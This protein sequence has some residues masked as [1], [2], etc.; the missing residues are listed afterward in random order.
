MADIQL[1]HRG[2]G[3]SQSR[4][5]KVPDAGD[6]PAA[7]VAPDP[8]VRVPRG[9]FG[10]DI[11]NS[12][13]KVASGLEALQTA[14]D[15]QQKQFDATETG[16]AQLAI[17][18]D[19]TEKLQQRQ[20]TEDTAHPDFLANTDKSVKASTEAAVAALNK[21]GVS[22]SAQDDFRLRVG[23]FANGLSRSAGQISLAAGEAKA[24]AT[25]D[26]ETN[27]LSAQAQRDPDMLATVL[28]NG[29]SKLDPFRSSMTPQQETAAQVKR[30]ENI[31]L[32]SIQGMAN[33]GRFNEANV[34]LASGTYDAQLDRVARTKAQAMID[35]ARAER[36]RISEKNERLAEKRLKAEG[37]Q[38]LKDFT[39]T[40]A[41]GSLPT[42]QDV[43]RLRRNPGV[44]P[45]EYK[46]ITD[47]LQ[48]K[49]DH[50]N[51][52]FMLRITPRLDSEDVVAEIGHAAREHIIT[53]KTA[54]SLMEKNR[55]QRK[56][57][58]PASPFQS[59]KKFLSVALDPG[60]IG[61]DP[62]IRQPLAIAQANAVG[63]YETWAEA[64]KNIDRPTA[65]AKAREL[66]E[67][68]QNVA[69]SQM[70]LALPR[71]RGYTG[72]KSSVTVKEI[73]AARTAIIADLDAK[74]LSQTEAGRQLE[75]LETW[76][77]VIAKTPTSAAKPK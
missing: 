69:F 41:G 67:Q 59:G 2:G 47:A 71:P 9:A 72:D 30:D 57:D 64:N 14:H 45:A 66:T 76:E 24:V 4:P 53:T 36:D 74:V 40:V 55:T 5:V 10:V 63:D 68:Y 51:E 43:D 62:T 42:A 75:Q 21:K 37:D 65:L 23:S 28:A 1:P 58:Q 33:A 52:D 16:Q 38:G 56:D 7:R 73:D 3:A 77:R 54:L 44:S 17:E 27:V 50:D 46:G 22:Q 26:A 34:L 11:G 20:V 35:T 60:Q 39:A 19:E 18:R 8:G 13:E 31:I 48:S 25:L 15:R 49:A 12:L 32:G 29:R 70:R 61:N 6:V